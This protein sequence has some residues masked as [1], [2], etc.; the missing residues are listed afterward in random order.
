MPSP[1]RD[2]RTSVA[3]TNQYT[4]TRNWVPTDPVSYT[5]REVQT[6]QALRCP[7]TVVNRPVGGVRPMSGWNKQWFRGTSRPSSFSV[8]KKSGSSVSEYNFNNCITYRML[9][10]DISLAAFWENAAR[11]AP[12]SAGLA[13]SAQNAAKT[14]VL[15]KL[16]Q[17]KW[18][19]GVT[20][21]EFRQTTRLVTDLATSMAKTVENIVN[22]RH[23]VRQKV[24]RFFHQVRKHGDFYKAAAEVGMT[25]IKLLDYLKD[26]WMQYQF[27][28]RPSL[29]DVADAVD[30]LSSQQQGG[31]K[32]IVRAK[33]GNKQSRH[34]VGPDNSFHGQ[35]TARPRFT[36]DCEV[37]YSVAY[38]VPTGQVRA[39]TSLGL[40]N[41]WS[42]AWEGTLLS[43]MVDYVVGMGNWLESFTATKGM[44][45]TEG[46]VSTLKRLTSSELIVE[47]KGSAVF[48][49]NPN[50]AGFY[51]ERGE[52]TREVLQSGL[53]PAVM[54][55]IRST[56]GLTQLGNSLFALSNVFSGKGAYR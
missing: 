52:F 9:R 32:L 48:S 16:S 42:V 24:D 45:F 21:V 49:K 15:S 54:P 28:I 12:F 22:S 33:G 53:T 30:W 8:T 17:K 13:F 14:A 27:G 19:L 7:K 10:T 2:D 26:S 20:A 34:I 47:P 11:Q 6:T 41:P 29:K 51:L 5:S 25:D 46:C 56:L 3:H 37:H 18:D 31:Q 1:A 55:Q 4:L 35:F 50:T 39:V 36:E 44:V 23:A 40:D 38:E 43:W